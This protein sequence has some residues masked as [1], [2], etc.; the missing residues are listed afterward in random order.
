MLWSEYVITRKTMNATVIGW[1]EP[2]GDQMAGD[3]DRAVRVD[4]GVS[5]K[6]F[7]YLIHVEKLMF[8]SSLLNVKTSRGDAR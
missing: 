8:S 6:K 7:R 5:N 1:L 2:G 3:I 4:L